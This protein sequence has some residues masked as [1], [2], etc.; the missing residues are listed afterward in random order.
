[1]SEFYKDM[2]QSF[3]EAVDEIKKY[4]QKENCTESDC[5]LCPYPLGVIRCNDTNKA[6][7]KRLE[8]MADFCKKNNITNRKLK[9]MYRL[10]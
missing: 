8:D 9:E 1:M 7:Q 4:C 5:S 6:N 3:R 2:P 10:K